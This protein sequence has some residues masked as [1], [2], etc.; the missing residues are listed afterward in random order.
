LYSEFKKSG[1]R[2]SKAYLG[3]IYGISRQGYYKQIGRE[4][5][6]EEQRQKA[7]EIIR[8][9]RA[10]LPKIGIKKLYYRFREIFRKIGVGRDKL[11]AYAR[12]HRLLYKRRVKKVV[13]TD[14]SQSVRI[15]ANHLKRRK[16]TGINQ[17]YVSDITYLRTLNGFCYLSLVVDRYS[18]RILGKNISS[19]LESAGVS[20]ALKEAISPLSET[21]GILHHSDRGSQYSSDEFIDLVED[22]KMKMSM[23]AKGNPYDNAVMERVFWTLKHEFGL[24]ETFSNINVVRKSVVNAIQI[25]NQERPHWSLNLK[26][27]DEVYFNKNCVYV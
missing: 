16:I 2:V 12:E 1:E 15:F 14:S 11:Y 17:A 9:I 6:R 26:T 5:K 21:K 7:L 3:K 24:K 27:P 18:R 13:T 20:Q 10:R 22:K 8:R 25:Y 19:S 4:E 23:S